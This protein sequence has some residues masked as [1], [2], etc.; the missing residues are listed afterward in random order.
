MW[1]GEQESPV[2]RLVEPSSGKREVMT[3]KASTGKVRPFVVCAILR[4]VT[5]TTERY[6]SFID[7]QDQLHRN[8]CRNRTLVAVGT[9]DYDTLQGPFEYHGKEP[10]SIDFVPLTETERSFNAKELLE[11]YNTAPSCKHLKPYTSIISEEPLYPVIYDQT[12]QVLSLPPIINGR[13]SRI[14]MHTKNVF[15]ECTATDLTK[16]NI[17]LDTVV[18]MFSEHCA[19][20]FTV[21]PVDVLYEADGSIETTPALF[22]RTETAKV[23]F[24]NSLIGIECPAERMVD[25]A[26]KMQLGPA[27][28]LDDGKT[29]KVSSNAAPSHLCS[30]RLTI[31]SER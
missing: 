2:Y 21:E 22:T 7:L 20:P 28:L 8:L 9:H 16:A 19:V 25:L 29:L 1:A 11:H 30:R 5:F 17:V 15:I 10:T 4:D 6:E 18:A 23:E 26:N 27:E 31:T 24:I 14:Q 3:V 12:G 13:H